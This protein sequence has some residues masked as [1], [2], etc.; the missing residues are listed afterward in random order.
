MGHQRFFG[1]PAAATRRWRTASRPAQSCRYP[2]SDAYR[3]PERCSHA[4]LDIPHI[5]PDRGS[6]AHIDCCG[7][8]RRQALPGGSLAAAVPA[9]VGAVSAESAKASTTDLLV[10]DLEVA[11]VTDTSVII[12]LVHR[13]GD[14]GG[15]LRIPAPR[16]GRHRT[17]DRPRRPDGTDRRARGT[18]DCPGVT[19]AV[20]EPD[21]QPRTVTMTAAP[22]C[23]TKG[24]HLTGLGQVSGSPGPG[25]PWPLDARRLASLG[26]RGGWLRLGLGVGDQVPVPHRIVP[27]GEFEHTV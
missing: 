9:T 27:D 17:A 21:H 2:A 7:P 11:T 10:T 19:R 26:R 24:I 22:K 15:H 3:S 14:R 13:P 16:R 5:S 12:A 20:P 18:Q 6:M 23:S 25:R 4:R 1:A 8:S